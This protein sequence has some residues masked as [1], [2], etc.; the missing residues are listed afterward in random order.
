M[1]SSRNSV[2]PWDCSREPKCILSPSSEPNSSAAERAHNMC[3]GDVSCETEVYTFE[4]QQCVAIHCPP[5]RYL[6]QPDP[7]WPIPGE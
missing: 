3:D 2:P 1:M 5:T 6:C 4:Y 7:N